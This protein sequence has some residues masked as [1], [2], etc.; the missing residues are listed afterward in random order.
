MVE[1][2]RIEVEEGERK[3]KEGAD[4]LKSLAIVVANRKT[5]TRSNTFLKRSSYS[6]LKIH[7]TNQVGCVEVC[8]C[9]SL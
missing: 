9:F 1:I 4:G 2:W 8:V 5:S 7:T 6:F 3:G